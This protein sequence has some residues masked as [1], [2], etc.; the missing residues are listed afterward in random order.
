[1]WLRGC[2]WLSLWSCLGLQTVWCFVWLGWAGSEVPCSLTTLH[3]WAHSF[4][5]PVSHIPKGGTFNP[6][7]QEHESPSFHDTPLLGSHRFHGTYCSVLLCTEG[8]R[9]R[10]QWVSLRPSHISPH[11]SS[12]LHLCPQVDLPSMIPAPRNSVTSTLFTVL[13]WV[14]H[15]DSKV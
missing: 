10:S 4:L 1:V 3:G 5:W 11:P 12:T 14:L 6:W 15:S 2:T 9:P 7:L 8:P 13:C